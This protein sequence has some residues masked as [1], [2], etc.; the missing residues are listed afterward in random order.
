MPSKHNLKAASEPLFDGK[1]KVRESLWEEVRLLRRFGG[2]ISCT[3]NL[4]HETPIVRTACLLTRMLFH[5]SQLEGRLG[6]LINQITKCEPSFSRSLNTIIIVSI[7]Q[8]VPSDVSQPKRFPPLI[9]Q[10][11][12]Y[13]RERM[14]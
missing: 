10:I 3:V 14:E 11:M 9:R 4:L 13:K 6:Y 7:N 8:T 2:N 12:I 1:A 5:E